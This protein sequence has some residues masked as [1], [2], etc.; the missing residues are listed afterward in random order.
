MAVTV[1]GLAC[2]LRKGGRARMARRR[3]PPSRRRR[4][5]ERVELGVE[6]GAHSWPI[7]NGKM[8]M[9]AC[10]SLDCSCLAASSRRPGKKNMKGD[11]VERLAR[12]R[13]RASG[14]TAGR[15]ERN[16]IRAILRSDIAPALSTSLTMPTCFCT[17]CYPGKDVTQHTVKRHRG[18]DRK[19]LLDPDNTPAHLASIRTS[20]DL[21]TAELAKNHDSQNQTQEQPGAD[22]IRQ[23]QAVQAYHSAASDHRAGPDTLADNVAA[24]VMFEAAE[25][26]GSAGKEL[27]DHSEHAVSSQAAMAYEIDQNNS[28]AEEQTDDHDD[29]NDMDQDASDIYEEHSIHRDGPADSDHGSN[30]EDDILLNIAEE[31]HEYDSLSSS[32]NDG[33][34]NQSAEDIALDIDMDDM[35]QSLPD[36]AARQ[37]EIFLDGY[38]CPAIPPFDTPKAKSLDKSET[39]SLKHW[40]TWKKTNGTV[41]AYS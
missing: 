2:E 14:I 9:V 34:S 37:R 16:R 22:G 17:S 29:E 13:R 41:K 38:T 26:S 15:T 31:H 11:M 18:A 6:L 40:V 10:G 32:D 3:G 36:T 25:G 20:I 4:G 35:L 19:L 12:I 21:C 30:S 24:D 7:R 23:R 8:D 28:N 5:D 39:M 33:E 1:C 27:S